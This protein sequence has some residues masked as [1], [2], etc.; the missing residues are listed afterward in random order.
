MYQVMRPLEEGQVGGTQ[1]DYYSLIARAVAALDANTPE[2]RQALYNRARAAQSTQLNGFEPPLSKAEVQFEYEVLE[3]AI[4]T[5]EAEAEAAEAE[6]ATK[7][8]QIVFDFATLM[9]KLEMKPDYFY[10]LHT[11]PHPKEAILAAIERGIV[12]SPLPEHVDWLRNG[13]ALLRNFQEGVGTE[14]LQFAG[15]EIR[16]FPQTT[17]DIIE[18]KAAMRSLRY[19]QDEERI[20]EAE[21]VAEKEGHEI[22]QRMAAAMR[23]RSDLRG[24]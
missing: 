19:P 18:L 5:V 17:T 23:M 6:L 1:S 16:E 2:S 3:Q 8:A 21:A 13:A 12:R 22:E 10:D 7:D 4:R 14:P 11:L 24:Q 15:C 9:T 20:K